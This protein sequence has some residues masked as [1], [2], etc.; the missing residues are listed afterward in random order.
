[1]TGAASSTATVMTAGR[2]PIV[3]YLRLGDTP[4]LV[5]HEC[6]DCGARYFDR[7]NGCA[8][9]FGMRFRTIDVANEGTI[10]AFT[11]VAVAAPGVPVPFVPAVVDC[12]GTKVRANVIN[13]DPTPEN[14]RV[15]MPVRLATYVVGSD[16]DGT[17]AIGFGFEPVGA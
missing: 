14:V 17:E 15:G 7:R 8:R 3:E 5:A 6:T 10:T 9:C 4:H 2:I 12:A 1:M 16:H 13:V 11:I